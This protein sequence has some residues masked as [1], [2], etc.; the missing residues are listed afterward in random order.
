MKK[1]VFITGF[2]LN[3][4]NR[5]NMAL[6]FGA[7]SFLYGRGYLKEGQEI[8]SFKF[9]KNPIKKQNRNYHGEIIVDNIKWRYHVL[10][11]FEIEE[12]LW[13][14]FNFIL[15]LSKLSR[16]IKEIDYE[17]ADYGG[18]GLSDIYGQLNFNNRFKYTLLLKKRNIPLL[19][20]PQTIGPFLDKRNYVKAC[21]IMKY[22]SSIFVRDDKFCKELDR[23]F[24]KYEKCRDL[25]SYMLPQPIPIEIE[26]NA[27]GLNVS[28]LAFFNNYGNLVG[29]FDNY[30]LLINKIIDYFR[31]HNCVVYLIPHSYNFGKPDRNNDDWEAC[32]CVY[33]KLKDKTNVKF[34]DGNLSSPEVKYVISKMSFFIGTRMH[35]N[36]AAIFTNVPVFGLAYSYKFKAAF[37]ENGLDGDKQTTMINR[38]K[39]EDVVNVVQKINSVYQEYIS[40]GIN[41]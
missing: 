26:K 31:S 9:V 10:N 37:Y 30:Q 36:F 12:M 33:D 17:A 35:A 29:E 11:F 15:P 7:I 13:N 24:L 18:D 21:E 27:V 23:L 22:A 3:Q 40:N 1:Y 16:L 41:E 5:G 38:L 2:D 20:L 32:K 39:E 34:V 4:P 6:N 28:G 19:M 8:V 25:S 14:K